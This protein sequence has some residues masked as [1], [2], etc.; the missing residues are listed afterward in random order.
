M[1]A[2]TGCDEF[3]HECLAIRVA[4]KFKARLGTDNRDPV[5]HRFGEELRS[6]VGPD[7]SGNAPAG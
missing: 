2:S 4:R 1:V 6:A 7:V 3:T 5:L